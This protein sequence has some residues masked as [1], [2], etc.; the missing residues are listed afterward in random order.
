MR[1]TEDDLEKADVSQCHHI[2]WEMFRFVVT[3]DALTKEVTEGNREWKGLW[4][5]STAL[6]PGVGLSADF[7][8]PKPFGL[9]FCC[10]MV[11]QLWSTM[12]P[13]NS[14]HSHSTADSAL[15]LAPA[16][17]SQTLGVLQLRFSSRPGAQRRVGVAKGPRVP[18]P[19]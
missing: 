16:R 2:E 6:V 5:G 15:R 10:P 19:S 12:Q 14:H 3:D 9:I 18:A 7:A 8:L 11:Q 1:S 13:V 4:P 17:S